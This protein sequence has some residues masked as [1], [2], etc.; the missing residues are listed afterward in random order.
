MDTTDPDS[1]FRLSHAEATSELWLRIQMYVNWR[2][3]ELRKLNDH[4]APER[5]TAHLRGRI[6]ELKKLVDLGKPQE[7]GVTNG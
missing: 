5:D 6:A 4:D 2:T 3:S 7:E 1:V